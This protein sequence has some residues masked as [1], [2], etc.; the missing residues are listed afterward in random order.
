MSKISN[1]K[2]LNCILCEFT[3][4]SSSSCTLTG[5]SLY[6]S[7]QAFSPEKYM[8][9]RGIPRKILKCALSEIE[10]EGIFMFQTSLHILL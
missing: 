6:I 5:I 8:P 1:N 3:Q 2:K 10:S 9:K 7:G 4:V